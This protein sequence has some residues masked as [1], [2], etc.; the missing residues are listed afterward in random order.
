MA[1][2]IARCAGAADVQQAVHF[3]RAHGLLMSVRGGGHS[4]PGYAG[5]ARRTIRICS[6]RCGVAAVTSASSRPSNTGSIR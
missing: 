3:A 2:L 1:T 6:G 5:P 4:A